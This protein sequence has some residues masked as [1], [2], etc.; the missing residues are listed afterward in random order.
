M[1]PGPGAWTPAPDHCP[2]PWS[3]C[4]I[5]AHAK[6]RSRS[7]LQDLRACSWA[8]NLQATIRQRAATSE[9]GYTKNINRGAGRS[10]NVTLPSCEQK[11][12]RQIIK[13]SWPS[14]P[15]WP[16]GGT[17]SFVWPAGSEATFHLCVTSTAGWGLV[18]GEM[19]SGLELP[20]Q[21]ALPA[22]APWESVCT[23]VRVPGCARGR[24]HARGYHEH[25]HARAHTHVQARTG[26]R[27][28][29]THVA[30]CDL[31]RTPE[32]GQPP[33]RRGARRVRERPDPLA[34]G[35]A[36]TGAS[37]DTPPR[38]LPGTRTERGLWHT[39]PSPPAEMPPKRV[40][41]CALH[42]RCSFQVLLRQASQPA[43]GAIRFSPFSGG[44]G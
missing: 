5:P 18:R 24:S 14:W 1:T 10:R 15:R 38:L 34:R 7:R 37:R 32:D 29:S 19:A 23:R 13:S 41:R 6:G 17:H 31:C 12:T 2:T 42:A 22:R 4:H 8:R 3:S 36:R 25:T 40:A 9:V 20:K 39:V 35:R 26:L 30:S 28:I 33:R 43:L 21:Q 27:S 16:R 44:E 11:K